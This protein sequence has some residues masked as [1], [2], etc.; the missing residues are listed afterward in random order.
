[1]LYGT[2][3]RSPSKRRFLGSMTP[4]KARKVKKKS[5]Q[6]TSLWLEVFIIDV[7]IFL[8]IERFS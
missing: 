5:I 1:M 4:C 8:E 7:C 2:A 6:R 3:V